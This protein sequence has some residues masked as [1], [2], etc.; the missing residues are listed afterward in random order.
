MTEQWRDPIVECLS[1]YVLASPGSLGSDLLPAAK[2]VLTD[3][4]A[5][6]LGA[7]NH[8]AAA[9][10]RKYLGLFPAD[11]NGAAIWGTNLK[12][13]PDK[14]T[15]VN[16]VLL[17]CYDY[18]DVLSGRTSGGHP[19]DMV[20]ALVAI[21]DW[22]RLSGAA[23]LSALALGYDVAEALFDVIPVDAPGWDHAT[24]SAIGATCAIGK[25]MKLDFVQMREALG[26]AAIQHMQSDEI[27][28][29]I[30]NRRGDLTMWKRFHGADAMRHAL[31]ACLLASVGAEGAVRPF[32][33]RLG[34]LAKFGVTEDL[35]PFFKER[36]KPG[37][38]TAAMSHTNLKRWPVGSRAQSAIASTIS[39]YRQMP[40]GS[41]V[42]SVHV[43][44]QPGVFHHL[45]EI[46]EDPFHPISR[47]TA[48]H[49]LP[50]IV[51]AAALDGFIDITS[52]DLDK[53]KNATRAAFIANNIKIGIEK[54]L[55]E[56]PG[57]AGQN[58]SRVELVTED[59]QRYVGDVR[60]GPGHRDN[61]F[62]ERDVAEKLHDNGDG[63]LGSARIDALKS[64]IDGLETVGSAKELTAL[65]AAS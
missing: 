26:I 3:T 62:T 30:T 2:R 15:L 17:R 31:D 19:S 60:P 36:L 64:L 42:K 45:V 46:R 58:L 23:L 53:V 55:S 57:S 32:S 38:L 43:A 25:L 35:L 52:F 10:A 11:P 16:G 9:I 61:P 8:P 27:E 7:F 33:G 6:G 28:S 18:N 40:K 12:A 4:L 14:A 29:S 39:A 54:S 63:L 21:A 1:E 24:V 41:V 56:A 20:S 13:T 34:F 50:Y 47:E 44:T 59:G 65:L 48:D 37:R 49:S 51:G 5:V 22:R